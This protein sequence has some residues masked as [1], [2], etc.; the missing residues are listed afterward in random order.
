MKR[1]LIILIFAILLVGCAREVNEVVEKYDNGNWKR[2]IVYREKGDSRERFK[3][4]EYY[5][6]GRVMREVNLKDNPNFRFTKAEKPKEEVQEETLPG[7]LTSNDEV[8]YS[9][10]YEDLMNQ[11]GVVTRKLE[12]EEK[13]RVLEAMRKRREEQEQN[14]GEEFTVTDQDGNEITKV[15]KVLESF[16]DGSIK[17][18][19]IF[20][21]KDE[22]LEL[23]EDN[24]Y[25]SNGNVRTTVP[26]KYGKA[27]GK[28]FNYYRNGTLKTEGASEDGTHHGKYAQ[29]YE[30]G[31]KMME[32][33]F[34]FGMMDGVWKYYWE[35]GN[36]KMETTF[37]EDK[38]I[39]PLQR[40]DEK[41]E[42]VKKQ[43]PFRVGESYNLGDK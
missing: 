24:E 34:K 33:Q 18:E 29:Y 14:P 5:E 17:H 8:E 3:A 28:W 43:S 19:Q 40:Y 9:G 6:D 31:K 1:L 15:R 25:Y 2:V 7:P 11:P 22:N 30:N 10:P 26:Y 41:G 36:R 4:I 37:K 21:K 32:G 13:E 23:E 38:E 16:E 12:G 35:N 27:N 39:G 20:I 42:P